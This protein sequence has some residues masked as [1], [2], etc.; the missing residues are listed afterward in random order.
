MAHLTICD[1]CK[2]EIDD[3]KTHGFIAALYEESWMEN[4]SEDLCEDCLYK[5]LKFT[6][7]LKKESE[8]QNENNP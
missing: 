2:K 3:G 5:V 4:K 8:A 7:K 1:I 6:D